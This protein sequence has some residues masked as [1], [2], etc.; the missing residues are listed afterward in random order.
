M[1]FWEEIRDLGPTKRISVLSAFSF[2]K[3]SAST[4]WDLIG[5]R[6]W[7]WE[8]KQNWDVQEDRSVHHQ[9]KYGGSDHEAEWSDQE[10]AYRLETEVDREPNLEVHHGKRDLPI[11]DSWYRILNRKSCTQIIGAER[12]GHQSQRSFTT[13]KRAVSVLCRGR[14]SDSNGSQISETNLSL[15]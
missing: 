11:A 7:K 3:F 5:R 13:L 10:E 14:K 4:V 9:H 1:S 2:K 8:E 12:W 6:W 15:F